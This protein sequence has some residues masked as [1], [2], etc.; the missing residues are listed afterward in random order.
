MAS[1]K[2]AT[3]KPASKP[4]PTRKPAVETPLLEWVSAA[5]GLILTLGLLGAVGWEALD[6]DDSPPAVQVEAMAAT[7]TA[8]GYVLEVR[9]ANHGGSPAA[10]VAIEGELALPDGRVETSDATFDYLPDHSTRAGGMFFT[11][12]PR[13]GKLTLRAKGYVEP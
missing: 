4:A 13:A 12:D 8:S 3:R 7:R 5:I 2:P 6:A 11:G 9:V 1:R 10:Q